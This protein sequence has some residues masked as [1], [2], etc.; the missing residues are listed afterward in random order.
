MLRGAGALLA[1]T[2]GWQACSPTLCAG[3]SSQARSVVKR[4][5]G[6]RRSWLA[7]VIHCACWKPRSSGEGSGQRVS[8]AAGRSSSCWGAARSPTWQGRIR[9]RC[10]SCT[11]DWSKGCRRVSVVSTSRGWSRRTRAVRDAASPSAVG[12]LSSPFPDLA[13]EC[14]ARSGHRRASRLETADVCDRAPSRAVSDHRSTDVRT[15]GDC[16][17]EYIHTGQAAGLVCRSVQ[18]EQ[19]VRDLGERAASL[20]AERL[21]VVLLDR[22]ERGPGRARLSSNDRHLATISV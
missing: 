20:L 1:P 14:S 2:P 13:G 10:V 21:E 15:A 19:L 6:G 18:A 8:S 9:A 17:I 5:T 11:V 12:T 22:P 7:A 16:D 4:G 3:A